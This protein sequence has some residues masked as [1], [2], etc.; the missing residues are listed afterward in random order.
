MQYIHAHPNVYALGKRNATAPTNHSC[1]EAPTLGGRCWG[2]AGE[3]RGGGG[4]WACCGRLTL[5]RQPQERRGEGASVATLPLLP[6]F[7]PFVPLPRLNSSICWGCHA[8]VQ[9]GTTEMHWVASHKFTPSDELRFTY[10]WMEFGLPPRPPPPQPHVARLLCHAYSQGHQLGLQ[11]TPSLQPTS[12]SNSTFHHASHII[13]LPWTR[14]DILSTRD[15]RW[16]CHFRLAPLY[17]P[18]PYCQLLRLYL[19]LSILIQLIDL[20]SQCKPTL[21]WSSY[22]VLE[23]VE[24]MNTCLQHVMLFTPPLIHETTRWQNKTK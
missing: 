16:E 19:L 11:T 21:S 4:H 1:P 10:I 15:L 9:L 20:A 17:F 13:W 2:R 6:S 24:S 22:G 12:F 8:A 23:E 18:I 3:G 7:L 14:R 5:E